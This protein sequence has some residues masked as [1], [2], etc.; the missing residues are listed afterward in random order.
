MDLPSNHITVYIPVIEMST[1]FCKMD[2]NT[3]HGQT[4]EKQLRFWIQLAFL[5]RPEVT[6]DR[7]G[8]GTTL[9]AVP[10]A[11][12]IHSAVHESFPSVSRHGYL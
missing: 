1:F 11:T 2:R 5:L 8:G 4:H 12:G 7:K 9:N 3:L 10:L 6:L